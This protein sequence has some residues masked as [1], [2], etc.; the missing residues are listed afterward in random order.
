[1][2]I[3]VS[4]PQS[5]QLSLELRVVSMQGHHLTIRCKVPPA[6]TIALDPFIPFGV[7][8]DN[9]A[10]SPEY[11]AEITRVGGPRWTLIPTGAINL[12]DP[13]ADF[14]V[15]KVI[16]PT[17]VQATGI[18]LGAAQRAGQVA[19]MRVTSQKALGVNE[20]LT[21]LNV[22]QNGV[23]ILPTALVCQGTA[24]ARSTF[25]MLLSGVTCADK[26]VFEMT[27]VYTGGAAP[28]IGAVE[29]EL[30]ILTQ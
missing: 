17:G 13:V 29:Y 25:E 24:A 11:Q 5:T 23:G 3:N 20:A 12:P 9:L 22:L 19:K 26:D 4:N 6:S 10:A 30:K 18:F 28:T 16:A 21:V 7:T 1:M 27:T 15:L 2:G 14:H 8:F